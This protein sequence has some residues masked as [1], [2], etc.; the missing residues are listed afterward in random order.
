MSERR[1]IHEIEQ[2]RDA[3][4]LRGIERRY[5]YAREFVSERVRKREIP[6]APR[7]RALVIL[8]S[9]FEAWMRQQALRPQARA[10]AVA[11]R[12]LEREARRAG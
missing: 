2:D 9:D 6:A 1:S 5:G 3:L 7:G 4:S 8:R 12:V 11:D 10:E